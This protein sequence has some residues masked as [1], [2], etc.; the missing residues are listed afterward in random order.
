MNILPLRLSALWLLCF[1]AAT[2]LTQNQPSNKSGKLSGSLKEFTDHIGERVPDL[3]DNYDIPGVNITV[4]Q[5]GRMVWSKAYGY[6]DLENKREMTTDTYC[7]V[8]S[9]SK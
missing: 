1:F 5:K 2:G 4:V 9:I 6:A 3:M 7:R 8:E